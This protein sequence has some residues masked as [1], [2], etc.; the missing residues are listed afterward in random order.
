[1]G[2]ND[3]VTNGRDRG[4]NEAS[5]RVVY[6]SRVIELVRELATQGRSATEIATVI[7]STAESVRA[8]CRQLQIRVPKRGRPPGGADK[9]K[10]TVFIANKNTENAGRD[11]P[12]TARELEVVRLVSSGLPNKVVA[13]RLGLREGTVK[14]HLHNIYTKLNVP[15]RTALTLICLTSNLIGQIN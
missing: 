15:N 12:L 1:M 6:T 14:I 4:D 13:R 9:Q 8:K 5:R 11:I 2:G 3:Y 10:L 7:G